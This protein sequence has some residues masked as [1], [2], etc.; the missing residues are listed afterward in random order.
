MQILIADDDPVGR[1]FLTRIL[2][3]WGY[4]VTAVADGNAAWSA[5]ERED[6][7]RLLI[8]D[9]MMPGLSGVEICSRVR[10]NPDWP[11]FY[12]ILLTG[13]RDVTDIIQGLE[14]GADTYLGKPVGPPELRVRL[15]TAERVFALES[16]LEHRIEELHE[17]LQ[18]LGGA[19]APLDSPGQTGP[20]ASAPGILKEV[21][22]GLG[23][24]ASAIVAGARDEVVFHARSA[25]ILRKTE[26]W[27][28]LEMHIGRKAA[29]AIYNGLVGEA[30]RCDADLLDALAEVLNMCQ[31]ALKLA[32]EDE[33]LEPMTPVL[34]SAAMATTPAGLT[35]FCVCDAIY[36]TLPQRPARIA[37]RLIADLQPRD[38]LADPIRDP[39]NDQIVFLSRGIA[40]NDRYIERIA[41][42]VS[43]G[44]IKVASIP[45]IAAALP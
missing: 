36:F 16:R 39:D 27:V 9:W 7:P 38:I 42:L 22:K 28:D 29:E 12:I 37:M 20:L 30:P 17:Q 3:K 21:L 10:A 2:T 5:I 8:L 35:S 13:R 41:D 18:R 24:E 34:P 26:T 23:A 15:K 33:G 25:I 32:L 19:A 40:L 6:P 44:R 14:A 4:D 11:Y 31:G 43:S 1:T 45:V